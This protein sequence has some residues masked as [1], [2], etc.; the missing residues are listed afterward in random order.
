MSGKMTVLNLN[1]LNTPNF[2]KFA[3]ECYWYT[4]ILQLRIKTF[5]LLEKNLF[6][7]KKTWAFFKIGKAGNSAVE[8]FS[9]GNIFLNSLFHLN[10][11]VFMPKNQKILKV[12]K[13]EIMNKK[14]ILKKENAFIF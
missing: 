4:K 9:D 14:S 5:F 1:F 8:C 11:E 3:A 10:F 7:E 6:F 13:T 12:G 2:C